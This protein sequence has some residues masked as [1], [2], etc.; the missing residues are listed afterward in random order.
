[1]TSSVVQRGARRHTSSKPNLKQNVAQLDARLHTLINFEIKM[2]RHATKRETQHINRI[3][4]PTNSPR[5]ASR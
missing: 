5:D 4:N 3:W 2:D 1:M